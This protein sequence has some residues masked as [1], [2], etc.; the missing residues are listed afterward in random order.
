MPTHR[1]FFSHAS[2]DKPVIRQLRRALS[3]FQIDA[4]LDERELLPGDSLWAGLAEGLSQA[5]RVLVFLSE[6][7]LASRWVKRE[8]AAALAREAREDQPLVVPILL[9]SVDPPTFLDDRVYIRVDT[10][11]LAPAIVD[12]LRAVFRM[13][14]V[15]LTSAEPERPHRLR[16]LASDLSEHAGAISAGTLHVV[17]D[18][19]H[20]ADA[21]ESTGPRSH[22][23]SDTFNH[24][25][26]VYGFRRSFEMLTR[27][28]PRLLKVSYLSDAGTFALQERLLHRV[29]ELLVLSWVAYAESC[30]DLSGTS[31]HPIRETVADIQA[32]EEELFGTSFSPSFMS[33]ANLALV[34]VP[35]SQC[36]WLDFVGDASAGYSNV[37]SVF[38]PREAL[39]GDLDSYSSTPS[40]EFLPYS[41]T[42]F[43]LPYLLADQLVSLSLQAQADEVA[44]Q[45]VGLAVADFSRFGPH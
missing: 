21:L 40:L 43:I 5:D 24:G 30:A 42:T 16:S 6:A 32:R 10:R 12:L 38:V 13:R 19:F 28:T 35:M 4:W 36:H 45:R 8:T 25:R 27:L 20:A 7:S 11:N 3:A 18:Y 34:N 1:V 31:L 14:S 44:L 2:V 17:F 26:L 23:P 29:W 22:A 9:G 37:T 41:W 39:P 15:V 33:L